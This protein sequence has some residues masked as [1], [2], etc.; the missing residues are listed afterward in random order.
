V[1]VGRHGVGLELALA[2]VLRV[3][4]VELRAGDLRAHLVKVGVGVGGRGR[5]RV[6]VRVRVRIGVGV[7]V[8]V[9]VSSP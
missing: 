5:V 6:R 4:E 2:R 1:D 9:R 7:R 8:R 3:G